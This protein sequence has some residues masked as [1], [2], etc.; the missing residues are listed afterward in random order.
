MVWIAG[1]IGGAGAYLG[2]CHFGKRARSAHR[3]GNRA[4]ACKWALRCR[5]FWRPSA[6]LFARHGA[7][8]GCADSFNRG[9]DGRGISCNFSLTPI[10]IGTF[11][12]MACALPGNFL[13]LR[14]TGPDRRCHQPCRIARHRGGDSWLAA[15]SQRG[16][17]GLGAA[18]AAIVAVV[19]IEA[20]RRFGRVEPGAAM[21]RRLYHHVRRR[22]AG[23]WNNPAAR[24]C[25]WM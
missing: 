11:A 19:L 2:G 13:I 4:G 18:G 14:R 5:C 16:P 8:F 3:S 10:L 6:G 21:G 23:C 25:I 20:I 7:I 12:A 15:R 1:G 17:M 9:R 24:R 22:G